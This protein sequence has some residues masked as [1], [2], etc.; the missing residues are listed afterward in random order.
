MR[1]PMLERYRALPAKATGRRSTP[2]R[3]ETQVLALHLHVAEARREGLELGELAG[4]SVAPAL[5]SALLI[6]QL[7][8]PVDE[9]HIPRCVA[10]AGQHGERAGG[11]GIVDVARARGDVALATRLRR[12]HVLSSVDLERRKVGS[13]VVAVQNRRR[14]MVLHFRAESHD[15]LRNRHADRHEELALDLVSFAVDHG[16]GDVREHPHG[17]GEHVLHRESTTA[18]LGPAFAEG[19]VAS[20]EDLADD[21]ALR[22][23]GEDSQVGVD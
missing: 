2:R 6:H 20:V 18:R 8:Q 9:Q 13:F 10:R 12:E 23:L 19:Q 1:A 17:L 14:N 3:A 11:L 4:G 15:L 5:E 21:D 16:E 7:V 22:V